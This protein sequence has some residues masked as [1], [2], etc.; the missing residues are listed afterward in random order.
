MTC[1]FCSN[2]LSIT[3][4]D[5][6]NSPPSNSY[7]TSEQLKSPETYYP[8]KVLVCEKCFLVQL[9]EHKKSKE[10]FN[11]EYAYF[12]SYS[13]SWLLHCKKYTKTII[14]RF[15]LSE[16]S[17]VIEIA[18]NDG[19]LL[20]YF[21][22]ANINILGIEPTS[23]TAQVAI[24]K[25][26]PTLVE[27]FSV[28]LAQELKNSERKADLIIGNNVLAHVPDIN[29]FISGMKIILSE[30][31]VITMEFPHLISLTRENQFDTIYHEH[32]S[33]LSLYSTVNIFRKN[34]LE[35]FDVEKVPTHGGSLRIYAQHFE[36]KN[37]DISSSV[38]KTIN[39]ELKLGVNKL[40]FYNGLQEKATN[41]KID[42]LSFLIDQKKLRR[43]VIAFGAAA[44]GN[45]L[46]N[47]CGVKSDLI[48]Y[49]VDSNPN[50]Q[51]KFL[52]ASHIPIVEEEKIRQTK[53]KYVIILPWNLKEEISC[54]LNYIREWGGQ[55]VI[56]IPRLTI[57]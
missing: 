30:Q 43:K 10:I 31:G 23:N 24:N 13:T 4:V 8:L 19:Y 38:N 39:E 34:G 11:H 25:G 6:I 51:N 47:F 3:F 26:I 33:Y 35:I 12:S 21:K 27:F 48:S 41:I 55:F 22:K 49:V 28:K 18:S 5:L 57:F 54:E 46:L 45:T 50:K 32:F 17:F 36:N 42:V 9:Q 2:S 53:P 44:K 1:R 37:R 15:Q 14:E 20:Q 52:P 29:D 56:F 7:L 40:S 16:N